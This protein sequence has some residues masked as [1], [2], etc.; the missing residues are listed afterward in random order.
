MNEHEVAA[1][2][3][4]GIHNREQEQRS[5]MHKEWCEQK[6]EIERL[7]QQ[8]QWQPIETLEYSD[9]P[10]IGESE[11]VL[12]VDDAGRVW[13]GSLMYAIGKGLLSWGWNNKPTHWMPLPEPPSLKSTEGGTT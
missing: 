12:L 11:K 8:T 9:D 7:R 10:V 5:Q 4:M 3:A 2:A 1:S 13:V 6:D